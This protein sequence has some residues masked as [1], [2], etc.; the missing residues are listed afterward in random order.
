MALV[1]PV[2]ADASSARPATPL[3]GSAQRTT[4][5][6]A[7]SL[8][9][10]GA[11]DAAPWETE[12]VS[13]G[14][15]AKDVTVELAEDQAATLRVD[16]AAEY[17]IRCLPHDFPTIL[18]TE[19]ADAGARGDGFYLLGT[20]ITPP[21]SASFAMV[22]DVHGTPVWYLRAA[23][24]VFDV[25]LAAPNVISFLTAAAPSGFGTDPNA[26]WEL[27]DLASGRSTY[28][29]AVEGPTDLHEFR[30]LANGDYLVQSYDLV[31]GV[32]LTGLQKFGPDS[33]VADCVLQELDRSGALVW[34]WRA[35][36]HIDM[37]RESTIPESAAVNGQTVVDPIH[38]N[39]VDEAANGDLLVSARHLDAVF[40]VSKQT[41][42]IVW[43]LGGAAYSRD[44]AQ[45]LQL[46][47]D[48]GFFRQ[49]D[50][51]FVSKDTISL[52]DDES[53]MAAPARAVAYSIDPTSGTA[54]RV[55]QD[56]GPTSSVAMGSVRVLPNDGVVVGWGLPS[57]GYGGVTEFDKSGHELFEIGLPSGEPSYRA[58]KVPP[59]SFDLDVLRRAVGEE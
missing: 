5:A 48:T 18:V 12:T 17:W 8:R 31:G 52:F 27:R 35:G 57:S 7:S 3:D 39:S 21:G 32:D 54:T 16:G 44:G 10:A 6:K 2:K 42:K 45:L 25:D 36:D 34:T 15:S 20:A 46:K 4:A 40:L 41:G 53:L 43:K 38:V 50:A 56:I 14:S 33:T 58:V 19:K 24:T 29:K 26:R 37:V 11:A 13:Y 9:D 59:G 1:V 30:I 28:V 23:Q 22:L 47:G 49:H 51:R 55:W